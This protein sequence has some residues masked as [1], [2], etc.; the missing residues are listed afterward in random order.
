MVIEASHTVSCGLNVA[1]HMLIRTY[2]VIIYFN[3]NSVAICTQ[4]CHN[5]GFC[6][7]PNVCRCTTGWGGHDCTAGTYKLST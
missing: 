5:N 6:V 1:C 7:T 4:D 2:I 3:I